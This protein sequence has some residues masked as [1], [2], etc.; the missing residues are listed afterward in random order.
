MNYLISGINVDT[1]RNQRVR[2]LV[3]KLNKARK[4]Q[5]KKID[6]LCNDMIHAHKNAVEQL[7]KLSAIL[8]F[9]EEILPVQELDGLLEKTVG[10]VTE[11]LG[12]VNVAIWVGGSV[13]LH[14]VGCDV[15]DAAE[16][17]NIEEWFSSDVVEH[18]CGSNNCQGLNDLLAVGMQ[19]NPK[20][21][22]KVS[23]AVVPLGNC[24]VNHGFIVVYRSV[25]KPFAPDEIKAFCAIV[26]GLCKAISAC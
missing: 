16:V 6:I 15:L 10:F 5:A 4:S 26:P 14:T 18:I 12:S 9:Y 22:K 11:S 21:V 17:K 1:V 13:R 8:D 2:R 24:R 20:L 23:L 3:R 7:Q 19:A 25:Q